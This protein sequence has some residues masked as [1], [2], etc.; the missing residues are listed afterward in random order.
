MKVKLL[1]RS[2]LAITV[3]TLL[4]LTNLISAQEITA[5]DVNDLMG[6]LSNW[7]RWGN[8]DQMGTL[9]LITPKSRV[10]AAKLVSSGISVSMAHEVLQEEAADNGNPFDHRMT[11]VGSSPGPWSGD[12]YGVTYHGYAHSHLD[13]LCHRFH[14]GKM[15][16]GFSENE[17]T[18]TGCAKNAITSFKDGIFARGVLID[19]PRLKNV[20]WIEL[21]TPFTSDWFD[22]W[23]EET[24]ITIG[25]G[26]VVLI[27]TGRWARRE[28]LGAWNLATSS[29]G[30]HASAVQWFKN[31][32]ISIIGSDAAL[33]VQPPGMTNFN[34]P[35]HALFLV[36]LGTPIF[37]NLDLEAVAKA[38]ADHNRWEFLFT[39]APLR[40]G[41]GTGSPL[42][43]IA[44]F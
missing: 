22:A 34:S 37:D 3:T 43:P 1:I 12:H 38:A 21:E 9:N 5:E 26:D 30:M 31:R 15:Y 13:A 14:D 40:V 17:V 41:G 39:T 8:D 11:S 23:E 27:R 18:Q 10:A 28:A 29:A 36:A 42:N 33:D 6:S 20:D 16:N 25:S 44:T 19:M 32:D 7:G 2:L 35:T 24:G 4:S